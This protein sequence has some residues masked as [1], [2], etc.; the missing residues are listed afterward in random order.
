[1]VDTQPFQAEISG[2]ISD[3]DPTQWDST[4]Q[5]HPFLSHSF[6]LALEASGSASAETGWQPYHICLK[7]AGD[8]SILGFL[9]QYVKSHSY[10]E[11]VFDH[12]WAHAYENAG[13]QYYP[14]LQSS[15]PFTPA[16]APRLLLCQGV[17]E[18]L[19]VGLLNTIK[20]CVQKLGI[21][22]AHLTF[23][24]EE[25]AKLAESEGFLI[26]TDQQFHWRNKDYRDFDDFLGALSSRKRKQIRKER[27]TAT[28]NGMEIIRLTGSEITE[29]HWDVFFEFY[30]DTGARK[31][32]QPYLNR[33]FFSMIGGAM[34]D[35]ILL[36]LCKREGRYVAGALN[37]FGPDTLYGRYWGCAEDHP[38]LHFEA[39]YYQA[40]DFAIEKGLSFVEAGAQGP[41][42]LARG[43]EPVLTYSAHWIANP[44][45]KEAVERF[46]NVERRD[47]NAEVEYLAE[48]TPFKKG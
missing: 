47:V 31:W 34:S 30:Q 1:M 38:C 46:L 20:G 16:T 32:G 36:V 44:S 9:P 2:N 42:K 14:K 12:A 27:K 28:A 29:E 43:Y 33:R 45:F 25:E 37:F 26:R 22:T 13:G 3:F 39:C 23:L 5:G 17:S 6:L 7:D 19:R 41:H 35:K 48:H 21:A 11:Y 24:P 4:H 18:E 8:G 40:I 15:I 10:G